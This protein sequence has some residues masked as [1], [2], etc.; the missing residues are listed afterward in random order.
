MDKPNSYYMML[1]EQAAKRGSC[2]RRQIGCVL[3]NTAGEILAEG[4]NGA[5]LQLGDCLENE[6]LCPGRLVLAGEAAENVCYEVCAETRALKE[7]NRIH[8]VHRV[9]ST[10]A[11]CIRCILSLLTT[12]C[13]YIFLKTDSNEKSNKELWER[14]GNV[15]VQLGKEVK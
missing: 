13:L 2:F 7:C 1:A 11:P 8:E 9:Y 5:P 4:Y 3:V 15:W 14:A 6:T 12:P 10:E